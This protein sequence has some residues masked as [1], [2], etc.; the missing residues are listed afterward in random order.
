MRRQKSVLAKRPAPMCRLQKLT[1][2]ISTCLLSPLMP[3]YAQPHCHTC[4]TLQLPAEV[5]A[6]CSSQEA[7]WSSTLPRFATNLKIHSLQLPPAN[8]GTLLLFLRSFLQDDGS[9]CCP[10]CPLRSASRVQIQCDQ[11][12]HTG[13][14]FNCPGEHSAPLTQ[15]HTI[16]GLR[17][18]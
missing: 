17:N 9:V 5:S 16:H 4:W 8:A 15:D 18:S 10:C 1:L 12:A 3:S 7:G 6:A 14:L 2:K 11:L 13:R